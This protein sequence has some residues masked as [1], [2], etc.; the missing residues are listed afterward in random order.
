MI[1]KL[2]QKFQ[3]KPFLT[4]NLTFS[5]GSSSWWANFKNKYTI[6]K[7]QELKNTNCLSIP[8]EDISPSIF[9]RDRFFTV[10]ENQVKVLK[11][12]QN[13]YRRFNPGHNVQN[14]AK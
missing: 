2:I 10:E 12:Y 4:Q 14:E 7:I 11:L 1:K 13:Q 9:Q 6:E 8:I 3:A 5:I